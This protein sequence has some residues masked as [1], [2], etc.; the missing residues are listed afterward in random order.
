MGRHALLGWLAAAS[1]VSAAPARAQSAATLL[2]EGQPAP[3][4]TLK[5]LQGKD[6][7]LHELRGGRPLLMCFFYLGS[8]FCRWELA[9]LA[10]RYAEYQ[11]AGLEI[12]CVNVAAGDS[13]DDLVGYWK[14]NSLPFP[15]L[16]DG[17]GP[18][19]VFKLYR[20]STCP[21]HYLLGSDGKVVSRWIGFPRRSGPRRLNQEL[22]KAGLNFEPPKAPEPIAAPAPAP[23]VLPKPAKPS[24]LG[25]GKSGKGKPPAAKPKPA[26]RTPKPDVAKPKAAPVKAEP[27][28]PASAGVDPAPA[29][30]PQR[31]PAAGKPKPGMAKPKPAAAKPKPAAGEPKPAAAKV[32][33]AEL[34]PVAIA[35]PEGEAQPDAVGQEPVVADPGDG[36]AAATP[37]KAKSKP[38]G[39]KP[40]AAPAKGKPAGTGKSKPAADPAKKKAA[41]ENRE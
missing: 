2:P 12:L 7:S 15:V 23:A 41:A 11:K 14:T 29:P 26:A 32:E 5:D 22:A 37:V 39:G 40:K 3:E 6:Q 20:G 13:L 28:E 8:D 34:A 27:A 25:S 17:A 33:P 30:E 21:T 19:N 4:F 18:Q 24:Y 1:L 38:G 9:H 16:R 10:T 35:K 36:G 31:K